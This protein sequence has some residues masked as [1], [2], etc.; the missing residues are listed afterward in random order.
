MT[1]CYQDVRPLL[2]PSPINQ[3]INKS[4][5]ILADALVSVVFVR[6]AI[7]VIIMFSYTPWIERLGIQNMFISAAM[8]SLISLIAPI[9]VLIY[10]KQ[11]RRRSAPKYRLYAMRQPFRRSIS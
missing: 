10:G 4:I 5:Q 7:S 11:A 3:S 8:L 1:D 6:N 9:A 2:S